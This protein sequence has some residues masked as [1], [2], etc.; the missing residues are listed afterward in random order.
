M[1][2][3]PVFVHGGYTVQQIL[4][5]V[6]SSGSTPDLV[7]VENDGQG[8]IWL[9][10]LSS[11][12]EQI[13]HTLVGSSERGS[14][15]TVNAETPDNLGGVLVLVANSTSD[16]ESFTNSLIDISGATGIPSWRYDSPGTLNSQTV[17]TGVTVDQ[18]GYTVS[19]EQYQYLYGSYTQSYV[20]KIDPNAGTQASAWP[21][22]ISTT[23]YVPD[24]CSSL[25]ATY[26]N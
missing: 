8:S 16:G 3:P 9:R 11:R 4:Q 26:P 19:V 2:M 24:E 23:V 14:V 13:W 17:Q 10:G 15:D 5:T 18:N 7:A 1:G 6:P 25:S 21:L 12:C 20:V 22:P